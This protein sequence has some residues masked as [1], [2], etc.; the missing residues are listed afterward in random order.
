MSL[1]CL[2]WFD[3]SQFWVFDTWIVD[4]IIQLRSPR[5]PDNFKSIVMEFCSGFYCHKNVFIRGCS[6][7]RQFWKWIYRIISYNL[8]YRTLSL[9]IWPLESEMT[10]FSLFFKPMYNLCTIKVHFWANVIA[11]LFTFAR[12]WTFDR[13]QLYFS[14]TN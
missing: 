1:F 13:H 8:Y 7:I 9:K 10:I 2:G 11:Y 4:H 5:L 14:V 6:T 12:K 3:C